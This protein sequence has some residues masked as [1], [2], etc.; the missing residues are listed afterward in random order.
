MPRFR[1]DLNWPNKMYCDYDICCTRLHGPYR[2]LHGW[3]WWITSKHVNRE[4]KKPG[5]PR[6]HQTWPKQHRNHLLGKPSQYENRPF[7]EKQHQ[8][9]TKR[10]Y[11]IHTH[12]L[13]G[14]QRHDSGFLRRKFN[15]LNNKHGEFL[16]SDIVPHTFR[17]LYHIKIYKDMSIHRQYLVGGLEHFLFF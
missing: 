6:L 17:P 7:Q 1:P 4:P 13:S 5:C 3:A 2:Q 9:N 14:N 8:V 10:T 11:I 15:G 16:Y 12:I